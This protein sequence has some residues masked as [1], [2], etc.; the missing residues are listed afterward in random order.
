MTDDSNEE[1]E[2]EGESEHTAPA[3]LR[4]VVGVGASAGG[5]EALTQFVSA[6]PPRMDCAY[7]VIQHLSPTYKSMMASLL[8]RETSLPVE[9]I[10]DAVTLKANTIYVSPPR[11]DIYYQDGRLQLRDPPDDST[12][13]KP[14]INRFFLSLAEGLGE[15]AIGVVLS[16]TGS[17]GTLGIR[18]IKTY[19]GITF[20]QDPESAK[21]DGMPRSAIDSGRVDRIASPAKIAEKLAHIVDLQRRIQEQH[22]IDEKD[23][24]FTILNILNEHS[25][26]NF[27]DYKHSTLRRRVNRRLAACECGNL[28]S[29]KD[30]LDQH[31][32]E[33]DELGK[34]LLISVTSFFRDRSTFDALVRILEKG[35]PALQEDEF[36]VWVPGCATGE[37]AYSI[38]IL[39]SEIIRSTNSRITVQVFA[40]DIDADALAL[41]R[42]G[43]YPANALADMPPELLHRYFAPRGNL[44]EVSKSLRDV[45]VFARQDMTSDPPFMHLDLVSCRNVLI[46]MNQRLQ[47]KVLATFHYGLRNS[48]LLFLGRSENITRDE[49]LFEPIDSRAR[50][51]Q[52]LRGTVSP[53]ANLFRPPSSGKKSTPQRR[54]EMDGELTSPEQL[55]KELLLS[56]YTP[57]AM[58]V[59]DRYAILHL[60][61]PDP[62]LMRLP[63]HGPSMEMLQV[64]VP[65]LHG[66]TQSLIRLSRRKKK[67][68]H[69]R[70]RRVGKQWVRVTVTPL[71]SSERLSAILL[72]HRQ[73]PSD[74]PQFNEGEPSPDLPPQSREDLQGELNSTREHLQTVIEELETSNEEMQALNEEVQAANEELQASNE[75]LEASNE[76]LQATNEELISLNEELSAKTRQLAALGNEY[77]HLYNSL[78]LPL[79]IFTREMRLSRAN[80]GAIHRF[81]L[82]PGSIGLSL[83]RLELP[84]PLDRLW[85]EAE[86]LLRSAKPIQKPVSAD[87]RSYFLNLNPG[88]DEQ[89]EIDRIFVF[90]L[91]HTELIRTEK[92]L[93]EKKDQLQAIMDHSTSLL[94]VKDTAGRYR[95]VNRR[96]QEFFGIAADPAGKTD[97]QL[98]QDP[99][100]AK[101]F[102]TRDLAVLGDLSPAYD[103]HS[104]TM[105]SGVRQLNAVRFP[106]FDDSGVA[107]AV[108][109]QAADVT[110]RQHAEEQLRLAAKVFEQ[111]GE[112]ISIT[113]PR[114]RIITVNQAFTKVT[115]YSAEEVIGK[116][117]AILK[118][119]RHDEE[120]YTRM[121]ETIQEQGWWQGEVW[122]RRKNGELYPEWLTI[123]IVRDDDGSISHY[124]GIFSDISA[125][126]E[127]QRRVAY[128]A[129]HDE[130]TGLAN[131]VLFKD[132]L[133]HALGRAK[134]RGY[135]LAVLFVD[136]DN[137]KTINDTL[138]HETGD[139]LLIEVSARL[140]RAI[141]SGD[142]VARM[143]GDEFILLIE[144]AQ[145][146]LVR[147]VSERVIDNLSLVYHIA[148]HELFVTCSI[149]V[150]IYPD[151]GIDAK[152]L[153]KNADSAMYRAKEAGRNQFQYFTGDLQVVAQQRLAIQTGLR[154]ALEH[155]EF[156]MVLQPKVSLASGKVVAAEALLRWRSP[157]LGQVSPAH[158]IPIAENSG[159]IIQIDEWVFNAILELL[160]GWRSRDFESVPIAI[161]ISPVHFLRG[162]LAEEVERMMNHY[163]V[164]P[165]LL[166]I[167]L[168]EGAVMENRSESG[169]TL[170]ALRRQGIG[171]SIDDFGTGYSSLA[172]LKRYPIDELKI[173]REFIDGVANEESDRAITTAIIAMAK[174]LGIRVVAEGAET[175]EQ[176]ETLRELNCELCQGYYF[177][178]P[179][180]IH[181]FEQLLE[182]GTTKP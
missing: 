28:E 126:K 104:V 164:D 111:S 18:D 16:G 23:D 109:T 91:D 176:V 122:N 181:K 140:G 41:A 173:D 117:P 75:E 148:N 84:P 165:K 45:M 114:G 107:Y 81:N 10:T 80:R 118:S 129:S 103:S 97:S 120:F 8:G 179:L 60:H 175:R 139:N 51:Y 156:E 77:E 29:Y 154:S 38:A 106:L 145:P 127:S 39:C 66:E 101:E 15:R 102:R 151:D 65:E 144:D 182:Q 89:G 62:D 110:L 13:P 26:I 52:R 59:D 115:G 43:L 32:Q 93:K 69:G 171:I 27:Q 5:L 68:V 162:T 14:S 78:D 40:T 94:A 1:N 174:S 170:R 4:F 34:E 113:D 172:Y 160:A 100:L 25:G 116:T 7:V 74:S 6:L 135:R 85:G 177:H 70:V 42:R 147:Q 92:A 159:L 61:R 37:E 157:T 67:P 130:L 142:L 83:S 134:R 98:F 138:G 57:S 36:R 112:G 54:G 73:R 46:Y 133:H 168:T 166:N 31:P 146:E 137:F 48:G 158:F 86:E 155:N 30:Y 132:E 22:Q 47:S 121:W 3:R 58:L 24:F 136:L 95:F 35:I 108:C 20:A 2:L 88:F 161:N 56:H 12:Q 82:G 96:F 163:E 33:L 152:T 143:G 167:E 90:L 149:G 11:W 79:L 141:R 131:R 123:N 169:E 180:A 49:R 71:E 19:G 50:I 153:I 9:E 17:D 125:I 55:I 119:G 128:L 21:Y 53:F 105:E 87:G 99:K 64:L 63:S 44:L 178:R 72:E 150:A 76:E 124:V